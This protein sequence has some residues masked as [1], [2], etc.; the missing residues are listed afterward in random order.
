MLRSR[1]SR[2]AAF[3]LSPLLAGAALMVLAVAA[4]P[5]SARAERDIPDGATVLSLSETATTVVA[6][7]RAR[8]TLAAEERGPD[9]V[10]VQGE[11]NR[12]IEAALKVAREVSAV[13][14]ETGG[15][16]VYPVDLEEGKARAWNGRQSIEL[17]SGDMVALADL[18][19]RLQAMGLVLQDLN[20]YVSD[21]RARAES[22]RLTLDAIR[23]IRARADLIGREI[24]TRTVKI[25][26]I[27][28]GGGPGN[29]Q[30]IPFKVQRMEA[31]SA[32]A[33]M[34]APSI[35]LGE[36]TLRLTVQAELLL[37]P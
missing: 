34:A 29:P 37:E 9:A 18:A 35:E 7:D 30:P 5:G 8:A 17:D 21:D 19:G 20:T 25:R 36:R 2:T 28:P 12:K 23:Q 26:S 27:A 3:S 10:K 24:G 4:T 1:S 6:A 15:Y 13:K 14:V 31:M 16:G 33:D 11:I 32:S 22:D